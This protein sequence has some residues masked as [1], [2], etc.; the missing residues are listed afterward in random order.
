MFSDCR[1][2]QG[3]IKGNIK[4]NKKS[5]IFKL[6][7]NTNLALGLGHLFEISTCKN[8]AVDIEHDFSTCKK[9]ELAHKLPFF[10]INYFVLS[11]WSA[12]DS[13]NRQATELAHKEASASHVGVISALLA[14][15]S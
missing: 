7:Q 2:T 14:L 6:A 4:R 15:A 13:V 11:V 1:I 5:N 12:L 3:N 10:L 9:I 8:F